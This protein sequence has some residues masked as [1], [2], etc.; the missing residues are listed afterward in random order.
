MIFCGGI[1]CLALCVLNKYKIIMN[2]QWILLYIATALYIVGG[3]MYI[4][5]GIVLAAAYNKTGQH[6][7]S[8]AGTWF[9][10][11]SYVGAHAIIFGM[12]SEKIR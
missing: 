3:L 9:S 2:F 7:T 1:I 10:E 6:S 11:G 8:Y 4:L 5:G 12:N